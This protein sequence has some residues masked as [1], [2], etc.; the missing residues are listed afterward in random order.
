MGLFGG[1][2]VVLSLWYSDSERIF[3]SSKMRKGNKEREKK[4]LVVAGNI[5]SEKMR[6]MKLRIITCF[7]DRTRS[8]G[9][10]ALL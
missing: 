1:R 3:F 5:K 2:D 9:K 10:E 8:R 4:S 6:G 7:G